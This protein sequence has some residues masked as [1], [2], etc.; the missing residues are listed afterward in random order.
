MNM[1]HTVNDVMCYSVSCC[2]GEDNIRDAQEV[3]DLFVYIT[4]HSEVVR[5]DTG[6][7]DFVLFGS[8]E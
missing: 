4:E 2:D 1:Y 7:M 3:F 8:L 5:E 6:V